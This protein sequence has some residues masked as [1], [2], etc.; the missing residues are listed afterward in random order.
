MPD[1]AI[2]A[3]LER[4][5][6]THAVPGMAAALVGDGRVLAA[7]AAGVADLD[8]GHPARVDQ[9]SRWYSITKGLTVVA[10]LDLA[11]RGRIDLDAPLT[12]ILP[13]LRFA[14]P[15]ATAHASLRDCLL[16]RT[17][18]LGG[19]WTWNDGPADPDVLVA[20]IPDLPCPARAGE[21]AAYQNL[22]FTLIERAM[23]AIGADWHQAMADI[24]ARLGIRIIT[25]QAAFMAADRFA[26]HGP[27][28]LTEPQRV[29]DVEVRGVVA[30]AGACGSIRDLAAVAGMVAG[31]GTWQGRE[32]LPRGWWDLA[33]APLGRADDQGPG[34]ERGGRRGAMAGAWSSYR[35]QRLL[36]WAGGFRGY[37]SQLIAIPALGLAACA[38]ANRSGTPCPEAVCLELL[39]RAAGWP[40]LDWPERFRADKVRMRSAG[41]A[42]L[43]AR[44]AQPEGIASD[45]GTLAGTFRHPAYGELGVHA[46]GSRL[47]LR[48]RRIELPLVPR[49]DGRWSADGSEHGGEVL[50]DLRPSLEDGRTVWLFNPDNGAHPVGFRRVDSG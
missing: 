1:A 40:V 29:E 21:R 50:W 47:R 11:R 24:A 22:H 35:G 27:N 12:T 4:A 9:P 48:F 25:D 15:D 19:D 39:D 26:P 23:A 33:V 31:S 13:T 38:F 32:I 14:N 44:L 3:L 17:G 43:A 36:T 10:V 18:L 42:R 20:G 30:G 5:C 7:A 16:H 8:R 34:D 6:R 28:G 37:T 41:A 46:D 45:P 2:A 49:A